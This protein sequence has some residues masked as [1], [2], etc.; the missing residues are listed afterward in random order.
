MLISDELEWP[1]RGPNRVESG[2][3]N[4]RRLTA[5]PRKQCSPTGRSSFRRS[6]LV[7]ARLGRGPHG[8]TIDA[9]WLMITAEAKL[10]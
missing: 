1:Q 5:G 6:C 10:R 9:R 7:D 2:S 4:R 3:Y 8:L